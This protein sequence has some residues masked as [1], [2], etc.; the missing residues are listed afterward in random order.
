MRFAAC[1]V[2]MGRFVADDPVR[3]PQR[4]A[5]TAEAKLRI[6][7]RPPA[8]GLTG[9]NHTSSLLPLLF[10]A[11]SALKLSPHAAPALPENASLSP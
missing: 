10:C 11:G 1:Q 3:S 6:G 5:G 2:G 7:A 8:R 9:I 4:A